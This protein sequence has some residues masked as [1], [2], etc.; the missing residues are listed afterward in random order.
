MTPSG[1][2]N[3][4]I[5]NGVFS[6]FIVDRGNGHC[7]VL[8]EAGGVIHFADSADGKDWTDTEIP[9]DAELDFFQATIADNPPDHIAVMYYGQDAETFETSVRAMVS[10]DHGQSVGGWVGPYELTKNSSEGSAPFV[11]CAMTGGN[12]PDYFGDYIALAGIGEAPN[13]F[14]GAWADSRRGASSCDGLAV[15]AVHQHTEG[16]WFWP[17][18]H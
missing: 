16:T 7:Q 6:S 12:F 2:G 5:R 8:Y 3:G 11:P 14:F 13:A 9:D 15:T 10:V 18:P 4:A 17:D 1:D